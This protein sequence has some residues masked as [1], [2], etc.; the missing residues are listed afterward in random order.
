MSDYEDRCLKSRGARKA[1]NSEDICSPYLVK[2]P[3]QP[4]KELSLTSA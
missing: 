3:Q 4:C 2:L 1:T